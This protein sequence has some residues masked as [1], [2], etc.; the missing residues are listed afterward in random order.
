MFI[1]ECS[2]LGFD[3]GRLTIVGTLNNPLYD[4]DMLNYIQH[5]TPRF[6]L[7]FRQHENLQSYVSPDEEMSNASYRP[8]GITEPSLSSLILNNVRT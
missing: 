1:Y 8:L 4:H 2:K 3:S 6:T 5:A 7:Y